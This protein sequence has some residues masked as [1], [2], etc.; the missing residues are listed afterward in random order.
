MTVPPADFTVPVPIALLPH[1]QGL[2]LPAYVT[3]DAAAVDLMAA[4]AEDVV[5]PPGGRALI[6][7]GVAMAIPRGY[8]GQV[9]PRSGLPAKHGIGILNSPGTIDSDYRGEIKIILFSVSDEPFTV[10]RGMRIAQFV[11]HRIPRIVWE[12]TGDLGATARGEG[13]FCSTGLR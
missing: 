7:T 11:I 4:V 3:E 13:G 6:P 8:E 9:R 5:I 12:E 10:T 2:P 1:A